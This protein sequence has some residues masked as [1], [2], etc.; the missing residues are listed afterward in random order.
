MAKQKLGYLYVENPNNLPLVTP[1]SVDAAIR[2]GKQVIVPPSE[3]TVYE[4]DLLTCGHCNKQML[5]NPH[6]KR[7]REW[8]FSCDRYLCDAPNGGCAAL[9]Y[10]VGCQTMRRLLG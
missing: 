1:E 10:V 4:A 6:R 3:M 7:D 9:K 5:K 2:T 8:C